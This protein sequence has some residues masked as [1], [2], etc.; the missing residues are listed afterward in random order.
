[1]KIAK[2]G[3][4]GSFLPFSLDCS[5]GCKRQLW[6]NLTLQRHRH[7]LYHLGHSSSSTQFHTGWSFKSDH[8]GAKDPPFPLWYSQPAHTGHPAHWW[9]HPEW[10]L[11][12]PSQGP[13]QW[14][15]VV[16]VP[17]PSGCPSPLHLRKSEKFPSQMQVIRATLLPMGKDKCA[18]SISPRT[19]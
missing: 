11:V 12:G 19:S 18:T 15:D 16:S 10:E 3:R 2:G 6:R 17:Q 14:P 1:M 13:G 7:F 4:L 8:L 9:P 5:E